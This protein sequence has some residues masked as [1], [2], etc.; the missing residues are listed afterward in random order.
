MLNNNEEIVKTIHIWQLS[1][2]TQDN[3]KHQI[4]TPPTSPLEFIP[5]GSLTNSCS[6]MD[7][8]PLSQL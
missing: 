4:I 1:P 8:H 5:C 3:P 6:K 2:L 7:Q